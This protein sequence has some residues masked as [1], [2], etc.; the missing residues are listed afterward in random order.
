MNKPDGGFDWSKL[1]MGLAVAI[2]FIMQQ[3]HA[4]QL[5]DVKTIVVPRTEV[6]NRVMHKDEILFAL[7]AISD[8]LNALEGKK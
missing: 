1:F 5:S 6:D 2:V 3:Y 7:K 4:M 8:R